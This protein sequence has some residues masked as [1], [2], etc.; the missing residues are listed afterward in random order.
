VTII[1]SAAMEQLIVM[2]VDSAITNEF[3]DWREYDSGKKWY[4]YDGVGCVATWGARDGNRIGQFLEGQSISF[5]THSIDDLICLVN[6]YLREEYRPHENNL[7][8]V[9][10]HVAGFSREGRSRLYHIFW[11]VPQPNSGQGSQDYYL[12][13][14]SPTSERQ[15]ILLYNGRN[16]IAD[17][18][19]RMLIRD[20]ELGREVRFN[21]QSCVGLACFSDFVARLAGEL[22]PEISPPFTTILIS[23]QNKCEVVIN[24]F[25][26]PIDHEK[27]SLALRLLG[28][29]P[30]YSVNGSTQ[31]D[32]L[33]SYPLTGLNSYLPPSG[34]NLEAPNVGDT[35]L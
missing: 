3:G 10:Y 31:G 15:P 32:N 4:K 34:I 6:R 23:S 11:G 33:Q 20:I 26:S 25:F 2:T 14:H 9:G 8:D 16:D 5:D 22:T 21:L 30:P 1:F 17:N 19:V 27:I 13:N 35:S 12:N 7:G 28:F 18:V 29:Q 24:R